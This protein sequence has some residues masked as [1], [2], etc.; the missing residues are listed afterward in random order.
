M[1][2]LR[3]ASKGY[4]MD[5]LPVTDAKCQKEKHAKPAKVFFFLH[6]FKK[7]EQSQLKMFKPLFSPRCAAVGDFFQ[8][9]SQ[10]KPPGGGGGR[11][12]PPFLEVP[13]ALKQKPAMAPL[14]PRKLESFL[15]CHF[16]A[17]DVM[18]VA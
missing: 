16:V 15:T 12:S 18:F 10:G 11:S 7:I 9:K 4:L 2:I 6:F 17:E 14:G 3:S 1:H 5:F 13:Q 8:G